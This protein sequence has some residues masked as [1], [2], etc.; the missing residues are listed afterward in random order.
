MTLG[1]A[2]TEIAYILIIGHL[3]LILVGSI[4]YI[5]SSQDDVTGT[6]L[7]PQDMLHLMLM[8]APILAA[9][10]VTAFKFI[11]GPARTDSSNNFSRQKIVRIRLILFFLFLLMFMEYGSLLFTQGQAGVAGTK[12]FVGLL[13]TALGAYLAAITQSLFPQVPKSD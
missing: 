6:E 7:M 4:I 3:S 9:S 13:E 10:A 8:G 5:L 1:K 2:R 11:L 12:S